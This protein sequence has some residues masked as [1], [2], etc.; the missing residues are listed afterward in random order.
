MNPSINNAFI[1]I[2]QKNGIFKIQA[3]FLVFQSLKS[4]ISLDDPFFVKWANNKTDMK[5]SVGKKRLKKYM[6]QKKKKTIIE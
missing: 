4:M 3:Q 1:V 2:G 5:A 6:Q